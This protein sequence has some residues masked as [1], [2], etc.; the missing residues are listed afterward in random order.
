VGYFLN[1]QEA[2]MGLHETHYGDYGV[3]NPKAGLHAAKYESYKYT[4]RRPT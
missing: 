3:V 2:Q 1:L 4:K